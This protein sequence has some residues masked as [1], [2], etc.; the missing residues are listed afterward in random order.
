[1]V[2]YSAAE[3]EEGNFYVVGR[4]LNK[5]FNSID[6]DTLKAFIIKINSKGEIVKEVYLQNQISGEFRDVVITDDGDVLAAGGLTY[7]GSNGQDHY[8]LNAMRIS[9]FNNGLDQV[10][11]KTYRS[12]EYN[13]LASLSFLRKDATGDFWA[14]GDLY[15]TPAYSLLKIDS[16]G[17][18][19]NYSQIAI[20]G[21]LSVNCCSKIK[22]LSLDENY[23]RTSIN[24]RD[25][26]TVYRHR[27]DLFN[28]QGQLESSFPFPQLTENN[29]SLEP[30]QINGSIVVNNALFVNASYFNLVTVSDPE[31][32]EINP[33]PTFKSYFATSDTF[34]NSSLIDILGEYK[35]DTVDITPGGI[36]RFGNHIFTTGVYN[37]SHFLLTK[38]DLEGNIQW[39]KIWG[40]GDVSINCYHTLATNDGGCI[41][42]GNYTDKSSSDNLSQL[43]IVKVDTDGNV[44]S[45]FV[46]KESQPFVKAYPN[47]A[48]NFINFSSSK[49]HY[50]ITVF[51][52]SG[53]IYF[54]QLNEG[55]SLKIDISSFPQG[56][57]FYKAIGEEGKTISGK[58]L[59]TEY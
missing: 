12:N 1:M 6:H 40:E 39:Q 5:K 54:Q 30:Q 51:D 24:A 14:G 52:S 16:E 48:N 7:S 46:S 36:S 29:S 35:T 47:P 31:T 37:Y 10:W 2:P 3:D 59:K 25:T 23:I 43:L 28:L 56:I 57:Y 49:G 53:R 20:N 22:S 38:T 9:K 45:I 34:G 21:P 33:Y 26:T 8:A 42:V 32:S 18:S 19:L 58:F 15:Y 44:N 11:I 41:M 4:Y 55:S 13:N 17:D 50:S 27:T